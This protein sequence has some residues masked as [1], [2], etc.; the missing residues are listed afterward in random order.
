MYHFKLPLCK[1]N[2][3]LLFVSSNKATGDSEQ[4]LW[5]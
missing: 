4:D 5:R 1:E 2:E 3:L